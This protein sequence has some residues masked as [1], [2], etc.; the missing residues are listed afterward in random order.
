M[1]SDG[2]FTLSPTTQRLQSLSATDTKGK[3]MIHAELKRLEP[4]SSDRRLST[5]VRHLAAEEDQSSFIMD[6]HNNSIFASPASAHANS[7]FAHVVC[8]PEDP[9]LGLSGKWVEIQ[10]FER[11]LDLRIKRAAM[12]FYLHSCFRITNLNQEASRS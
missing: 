6:V 3:H 9:I 7:V 2:F 10:G 5:L 12:E 11:Q 8:A 4:R 1:Q